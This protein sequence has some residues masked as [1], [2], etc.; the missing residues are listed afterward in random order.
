MSG[1]GEE[2]T[3][4]LLVNAYASGYF[5]MAE[6][7]DSTEL[8][9]FYPQKRGILPLDAFHV[10]AS[11]AKLCRKKPFTI[12]TD[13]AFEA[14]IRACA[15]INAARKDTWINDTIIDLYCE[16]YEHGFAHSVECWENNKLVGGLYGVAIGGAFFGESMFSRVPNASRVALVQLV[17]LLKGA[18]YTL[19]DTQF[20][21]EHL[22]QFGV[23]EIARK[24]YLALLE[25]A[26][27]VKT[28]DCFSP[29]Q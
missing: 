23:V 13:T 6:H 18:G 1:D 26:I 24:K 8:R 4:Q 19:L 25:E 29:P 11:L 17:A 10:P 14:V 2:I 9:W 5:P 7:R 3:W 16:L 12:T 15:D 28:Q 21:N 20:V 27:H 22:K